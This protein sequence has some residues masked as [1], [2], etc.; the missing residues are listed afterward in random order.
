MTDEKPVRV[1][2]DTE[3]MYHHVPVL[4]KL[5]QPRRNVVLLVQN[6]VLRLPF[7]LHKVLLGHISIPLREEVAVTEMA[8]TVELG[9][10]MSHFASMLGSAQ[11]PLRMGVTTLS[12]HENVLTLTTE[13]DTN[14]RLSTT[15]P[16]T[17]CVF[18]NL[19]SGTIDI[20]ASASLLRSDVL[21]V[22]T[23]PADVCV[24]MDAVDAFVRLRLRVGSSCLQIIKN[25]AGDDVAPPPE[26]VQPVTR[27][28]VPEMRFPHHEVNHLMLAMTPCAR[29]ILGVAV[30]AGLLTVQASSNGAEI[31]ALGVYLQQKLEQHL[32]LG[33][34]VSLLE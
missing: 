20:D 6:R 3:T 23:R 21:A 10:L 33:F 25:A 7:E 16:C 9:M 1:S 8:F 29:V 11:R 19:M 4:H 22:L 24:S 30:E 15:Q 26:D 14:T 5:L 31:R 12:F 2:V 34:A 13:G 28:I 27:Q 32:I 17:K 18:D